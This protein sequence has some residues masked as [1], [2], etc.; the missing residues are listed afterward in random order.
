IEYFSNDLL[1]LHRNLH[2]IYD[3]SGL[4][5]LPIYWEDDV[6][7]IFFQNQFRLGDLM[8][9]SEGMKIFN[10]HPIHLYLNTNEF[11]QYLASKD[12]LRD[13]KTAKRHQK[14]GEGIRSLFLELLKTIHKSETSTL[15]N[16]T[17]AFK[18]KE[19]YRGKYPEH[20]FTLEK[21]T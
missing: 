3:W 14:K 10:F 9:E 5:R 15:L 12:E 19:A 2:P 20:L 17:K 13:M 16:V 21:A 1:F 7:C 4:V 6:H 18:K 11:P 8:L